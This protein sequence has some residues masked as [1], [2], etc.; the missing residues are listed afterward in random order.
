MRRI[1]FTKNQQL[2]NTKKNRLWI[3][4]GISLFPKN[5]LAEALIEKIKTVLALF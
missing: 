1:I 5:G 3:A 2:G 4:L